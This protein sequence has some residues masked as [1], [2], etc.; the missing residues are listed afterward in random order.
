MKRKFTIL[1]VALAL[2]ALFLGQ[3]L[4][5]ALESYVI[6]T[7]E[8]SAQ[9]SLD[10]VT[11]PDHRGFSAPSRSYESKHQSSAGPSGISF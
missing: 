1:S 8:E 5:M 9:S 7:S 6:E 11:G 2:G 10:R 3:S 4:G